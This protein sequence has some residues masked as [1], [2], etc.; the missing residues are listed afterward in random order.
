V[1]GGKKSLEFLAFVVSAKGK[2]TGKE[3]AFVKLMR[4]TR[5]KFE[6]SYAK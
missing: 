1:Y 3:S 5:E 4:K 6:I 2:N